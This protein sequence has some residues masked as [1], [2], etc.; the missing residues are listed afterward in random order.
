MR[1]I[2]KAKE[3]HHCERHRPHGH[4]ALGSQTSDEIKGLVHASKSCQ[5]FPHR[6]T[7]P[8]Y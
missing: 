4:E 2:T 8:G 5:N 6:A 1:I 7:A 3:D